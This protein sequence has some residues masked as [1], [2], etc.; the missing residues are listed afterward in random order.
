MRELKYHE[1]KLLR[2]VDLYSWKKEDN[3]RV[4]K[5]LRRYH[6]QDR[7]DYTAYTRIVG[8]VTKLSN[9]LKTLKS[10]DPFRVAM[11]DQLL[12]KLSDLGLIRQ[13]TSLK[14]ADDLTA[15]TLCRRRLP[16]IMVRL[17]MAENMRTAVTFVEQGQ[18]RVGPHVVTDPAFLVTKGMEDYVT[19]VDTSKVRRTVQKYND[20]LDDFDL[21]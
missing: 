14:Q 19:W 21:L 11:T 8:M 20:K 9:K 3:V 2:K 1:K 13:A 4:A 7:E 15:S 6:I 12:T 16:V 5:I 10:D 18:V 17:K